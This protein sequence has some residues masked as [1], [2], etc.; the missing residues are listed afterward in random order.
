LLAEK[1]GIDYRACK[2]GL[3]VIHSVAK[4]LA[5]WKQADM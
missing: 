3:D 4:D 1:Y 2:N 5:V